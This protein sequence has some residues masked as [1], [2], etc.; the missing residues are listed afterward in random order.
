M[1]LFGSWLAGGMPDAAVEVRTD[2]ISAAVIGRRDARAVVTAHASEPLPA[3]AVVPS[4]LASNV[5]DPGATAAALRRAIERLPIRPK[6]IGLVIPDSAAK[7]SLVRFDQVPS[8]RDDLDQLVRW[9]MRKS[10]PFPIDD[11]AVTYTPGLQTGEK[12]REYL[13]VAARRAIVAEYEAVCAAVGAHAG[14]VDLTT[15]S[16]V[17]MFLAARAA[18]GGDWLLVHV[19]SDSTSIVIMRGDDVV[20]YRNRAEGDPESL[21]DL[22][23]QTT[24]YY[25]DRLSGAGFARVLVGGAGSVEAARQSLEQHLG[26]SVESVDPTSMATLTDRLSASPDLVD[27]LGPLIGISLRTAAPVAA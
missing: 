7:L 18:P 14:L 22:V 19:R 4:F 9:H 25:Q 15:L 24:M 6:R 17:N 23:H 1:S 2:R 21:T 8:R 10:L 13:V 3:G 16:L 27:V 20:F 26:L 5:V 11:A 12:G